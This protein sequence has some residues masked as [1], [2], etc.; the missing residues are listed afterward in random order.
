MAKSLKKDKV[1]K[2]ETLPP[3]VSL[4]DQMLAKCKQ[5][6][7]MRSAIAEQQKELDEIRLQVA[8]FMKTARLTTF[9]GLR[10]I[11]APAE[12]KWEG[13]KGREL[14]NVKEQLVY[15]LPEKFLKQ[16]VDTVK[17]SNALP[18]KKDLQRILE[19][20]GVALIGDRKTVTLKLVD[21][22]TAV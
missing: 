5:I 2:A 12:P 8:D 3:V 10:R 18:Y 6:I 15:E 1:N 13:L 16:E 17:L 4:E 11:E 7:S 20:K 14:E 21:E 19:A 22:E 9:G